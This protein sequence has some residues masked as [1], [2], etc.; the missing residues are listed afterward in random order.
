MS[1]AAWL[2]AFHIAALA[3]W[4]GGLLALPGLLVRERAE[5]AAP[6]GPYALWQHRISRFTY[7]VL[8]SPA[9]LLTIASG[10]ALIFAT[11]PLQ[12]W[13]FVKLAA[14]GVLAVIHI[15]IGRIIDHIE[16]PEVAP[17][18]LRT[19]LLL[20]AAA[21]SI[22]AILWLVLQKPA[23]EDSLFPGWLLRGP[24]QLRPSPVPTPT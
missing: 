3:V 23:F 8:V 18:R 21:A 10:T 9:A 11:R 16:S 12:G 6:G 14:V 1:L 24:G 17:T 20:A 4:A 13:L 15:Q 7:D 19:G 5:G 2:K 22:G